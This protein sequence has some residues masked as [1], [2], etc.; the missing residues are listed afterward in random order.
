MNR[1]FA[2][3]GASAALSIIFAS[4][5]IVPAATD[6]PDYELLHRIAACRSVACVE[7]NRTAVKQ[8]TEWTVFFASW[9]LLKPSNHEAS[10][11]LLEN[12]PT[13]DHEQMLLFTLPVWHKGATASDEQREML[14]RVY[15][16]WP[17]LLTVAVLRWPEF[18]PAYIG[19]GKLAA[20]YL[21]SDY[22][23]NERKV[24]RKDRS[25]FN[26]AF[27][28]LNAEDQSVIRNFVFD[29]DNCSAILVTDPFQ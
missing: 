1:K 19:Y 3:I 22:A 11:G 17:R 27:S 26:S 9:L 29:P 12:I 5:R 15:S 8:K 23:D 28:I 16:E 18:L 6:L 25:A 4:A 7:A 10:R 2:I 20:H 14:D 21:H 13:T 24:C